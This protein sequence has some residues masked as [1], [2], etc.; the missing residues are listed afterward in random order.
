MPARRGSPCSRSRP[1]RLTEQREGGAID[2]APD[3]H[4]QPPPEPGVRG[5]HHV[6][7]VFERLRT[8]TEEALSRLSDPIEARAERGVPCDTHGD[9]RLDHIYWFPERDPPND[10]VI[11]DCIEFDERYRHADPIADIAFLVMELIIRGHGDL[12]MVFTDA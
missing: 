9:L 6:G 8:L 7:P 10:W 12:A 5:S 11:V 1:D 3:D 4:R 2:V